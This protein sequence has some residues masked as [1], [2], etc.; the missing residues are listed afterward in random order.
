VIAFSRTALIIVAL[1]LASCSS[2]A[3]PAAT[4]TTSTRTIRFYT[5]SSTAPL[6]NDLAAAY[7]ETYPDFQLD[8]STASNVS[9]QQRAK[10]QTNTYFLTNHL[11]PESTLWAAPVGQDGLAIITHLDTQTQTVTTEQ[12]RGIYQGVI[13][14]WESLG[15]RA[16]PI[17]VVSREP[18]A[19]GRQ[20][21]ERLL[22]GNRTILPSA[23][24]V[25]SDGAML[26]TVQSTPGSIGYLSIASLTASVHTLAVDGIY[27]TPD[28]IMNNTYPLRSTLFV[29]G[30][31]EPTGDYRTFIAWI[32]S[33]PGQ[34]IVTQ[35]YSPVILP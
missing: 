30:S 26:Q 34:T 21:F 24:V 19:S 33:P 1:T 27:P 35:R 29:V 18:E 4:P 2:Q 25:P 31:G 13:N 23:L 16:R 3:I 12:V 32:Q 22:M 14:D 10:N 8:I 6:L 9:L 7:S 5:T 15:S 11:P 20:E 28:N 17:Q